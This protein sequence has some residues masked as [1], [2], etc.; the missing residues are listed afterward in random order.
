[1]DAQ[2]SER[3]ENMLSQLISMVGSMRTEQTA[4]K[5]EQAAMREELAEIKNEQ[6]DM[7]QKMTENDKRHREIMD[8]FKILRADQDHIWK[9]TV[10]N[11]RDINQ[12]KHQLTN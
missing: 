5:E 4:M 1:M 6:T 9:K 3:M 11:E 7:K 12:L 10:Q 8:E 2:R